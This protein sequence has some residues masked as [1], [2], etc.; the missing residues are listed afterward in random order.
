MSMSD[1]S[2][3]CI[4]MSF[5]AFLVKLFVFLQRFGCL[6]VIAKRTRS[7]IKQLQTPLNM[8]IIPID[9]K[10]PS[11]YEQCTLCGVCACV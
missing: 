8:V 6:N 9:R 7:Q 4:F 11:L 10:F 1:G 3:V 2:G 5:L